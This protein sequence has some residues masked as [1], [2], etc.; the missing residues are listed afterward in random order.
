[1]LR[2]CEY[3]AQ[4]CPSVWATKYYELEKESAIGGG[5]YSYEYAP[6]AQLPLEYLGDDSISEVTL[7]FASQ[8]GKT[9]IGMVYLNYF[10]DRIGGNLM[11]FLPDE[12]LIPFTATDRIL[13]AI[14]R[15][16]NADGLIIEKEERKTRDNTRNIRYPKG[17]IR[18]LSSTNASNRKS[19]PTKV[20]ILDEISEMKLEHVQ[21]ISERAKTYEMYGGKV[22][23]TS[24][25]MYDDDPIILAYKASDLKFQYEV[26][27]PYCKKSHIDNILE[28]LQY[29]KRDEVQIPDTILDESEKTLYYA[30]YASKKARYKCPH[31]KKLWDT[32]DKNKA[33]KQG[34]WKLANSKIKNAK[35]VSFKASSFISMFVSIEKITYEFLK[36]DN[37][38][39]KAV[40][41][42]GWL[43]QIYEPE[44][45]TTPRET[46]MQLRCDYKRNEL[47]ENTVALFVSIDVQKDH[48]Y[49]VT[50]AVDNNLDTFIV[51]YGRLNSWA[52]LENFVI[53][54]KYGDMYP[55]VFAIDSGYLA[56][57]IY[58]FCLRMNFLHY[59][60]NPQIQ[61]IFNERGGLLLNVLPVKGS[62]RDTHNALRGMSSISTIDKDP[63]TGRAYKD[64]LQ[65]HVINTYHF[66]DDLMFIIDN[67]IEQKELRKLYIHNDMLDDICESLVSETKVKEVNAKGIPTYRYAP[68]KSNPF[69][70]YLDCMV[71]NLYLVQLME[72]RWRTMV[73]E[74]STKIPQ[75]AEKSTDY[76][77]EF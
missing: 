22:L 39:K 35:S 56:G 65:L 69:N 6:H 42:R 63:T 4:I 30:S 70:H 26:K 48:F 61:R 41:Y 71:Y 3:K 58:E 33:I 40:F 49:F 60:E 59:N 7:L 45:K 64:S 24:T 68:V 11:F 9:T 52:E 8:V 20:I 37:D 1:M 16:V 28:H 12:K 10:M 47:P 29:P 53:F 14:Q 55:E 54:G 5:R 15:S 27:C 19:M 46:I 76:L 17:V 75:P 34:S 62:S 50:I 36:A 74:P 2:A 44:I 13:P 72:V 32:Q 66:K 67:T 38:E 51:D 18:V 57:E 25:L 73:S 43:S 23:K 77:D 31:C 21:E